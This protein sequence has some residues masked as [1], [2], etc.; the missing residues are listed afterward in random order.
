M[1][2]A[3]FSTITSVFSHWS[4]LSGN[5][6]LIVRANCLGGE[7]SDIRGELHKLHNVS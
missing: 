3:M 7:L 1:T 5:W 4:E 6:G 2:K